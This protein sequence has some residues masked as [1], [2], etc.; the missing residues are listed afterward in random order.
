MED[1]E[2]LG[3]EQIRALVEA[4]GEVRFHCQDRGELYGWVNQT[5]RRQDYGHLK[6][7]SKGLMRGYVAKMTGL[8]RAQVARLIR[9]CQRGGEVR[10]RGYRRHRFPQ[11]YTRTVLRRA[12]IARPT[13]TEPTVPIKNP[14]K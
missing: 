14:L 6:R 1:G 5:L 3:L 4:S 13:I 10:P 9:C 7:Q 11:R 12:A 8:S 2:R